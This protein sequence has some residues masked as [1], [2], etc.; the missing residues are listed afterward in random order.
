MR[1]D[2]FSSN[3]LFKKRIHKIALKRVGVR[4]CINPDVPCT[5]TH[6]RNSKLSCCITPCQTI[7]RYVQFPVYSIPWTENDTTWSAGGFMGTSN[8]FNPLLVPPLSSPNRAKKFRCFEYENNVA[9]CKMYIFAWN[10]I[11]KNII[12]L[13]LLNYE[14]FILLNYKTTKCLRPRKMSACSV[15][16]ITTKLASNA[17]ATVIVILCNYKQ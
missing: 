1:K 8:E 11:S 15:M 16:N 12:L 10:L 6:R 13:I 5:L 4:E 2:G 9:Q 14:P 17:S 7:L 3:F